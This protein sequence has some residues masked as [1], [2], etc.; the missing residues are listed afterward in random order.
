MGFLYAT[1]LWVDPNVAL[2]IL[3]YSFGAIGGSAWSQMALG[4]RYWTGVGV[5]TNCE[6]GKD[7]KLLL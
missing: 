3:H 7:M 5:A 6:K 4:Y 2:P 1:G